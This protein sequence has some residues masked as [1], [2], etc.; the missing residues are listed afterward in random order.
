MVRNIILIALLFIGAFSACASSDKNDKMREKYTEQIEKKFASKMKK[1]G[2]VI[3]AEGG[4]VKEGKI[5]FLTYSFASKKTFTIDDAR[6]ALVESVEILLSIINT[7]PKYQNY[8]HESPFSLDNVNLFIG[9]TVPEGKQ[10]DYIWYCNAK[11]GVCYYWEKADE[12][13]YPDAK[14]IHEE[15]YEEA[16]KIV[17][18]S[19]EN[20]LN[21]INAK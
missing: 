8:L 4:S 21:S 5:S 17:A 6:K 10:A 16:L 20:E 1:K 12:S 19:K 14:L 7:N 11:K 13:L 15:T 3:G 9:G 18:A 2:F